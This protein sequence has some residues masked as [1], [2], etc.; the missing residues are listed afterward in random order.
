MLLPIFSYILKILGGNCMISG[1]GFK[2][3]Q[4]FKSGAVG[5]GKQMKQVWW[6]VDGY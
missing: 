3:P 4:H 1:I 5:V 6:K 2:M